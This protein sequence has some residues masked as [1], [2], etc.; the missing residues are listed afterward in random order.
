MVNDKVL[1]CFLYAQPAKADF[2]LVQKA[3]QGDKACL[4]ELLV[5]VRDKIYNLSLRFLWQPADAEDAT[6][7]I[8]IRIMTAL[9]SFKGNSAFTTW[10]YRIAVNFL[11]NRK[12]NSLEQSFSSFQTFGDD[13]DRGLDFPVYEKTD[14]ALLEQEV[15]IGCTLGMLLCLHRDL[16][17]AFIFGSVFEMRGDEAA[18]I[19]E[20]TSDNFRKRLSLAR[21]QLARFM[22]NKCGL[23]N[24][25]SKCRC[26]KRIQYAI[27]EK[28]IDSGNLLF[29]KDIQP[30]IAEMERLHDI[31]EIYKAHHLYSSRLDVSS[32]LNTVLMPGAFKILDS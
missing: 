24:S 9:G 1:T 5:S 7:E 12:K 25:D 14:K 23:I 11:L 6:Q 2:L 31:A 20:I 4:E 26:T 16:R 18:E 19:L 21:K 15:K 32:L 13:L 10:C 22:E 17:L 3:T 30:F 8:L 27:Q 29:T 28:R